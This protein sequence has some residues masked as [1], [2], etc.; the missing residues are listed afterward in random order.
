MKIINHEETK[1]G[2]M[3]KAFLAMLLF[4]IFFIALNSKSFA[5]TVQPL[6][7]ILFDGTNYIVYTNDYNKSF[8]Y[9]FG[10]SN[11]PPT[12]FYQCDTDENSNN[13]V[14]VPK[15]NIGTAQYLYT[16]LDGGKTTQVFEVNYGAA[17]N[18]TDAKNLLDLTNLTQITKDNDVLYNYETTKT[19]DPTNANNTISQTV[20]YAEITDPASQEYPNLQYKLVKLNGLATDTSTSAGNVVDVLN[21]LNTNVANSNPVGSILYMQKFLAI[22]NEFLPSSG[23]ATIPTDK[24]V[25]EPLDTKA[26]EV[27]LLYLTG[28]SKTTGKTETVVKILTCGQFESVTQGQTVV[29]LPKTGASF[30]LEGLL[31]IDVILIGAVY[32]RIRNLKKRI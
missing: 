10:D 24:K 23:W 11:T 8:E 14:I 4:A 1:W 21:Q 20:Y 18:S 30:L 2:N 22:Y 32:F 9:A 17:L 28:T 12:V 5:T 13:V 27:Y 3:A 6:E 25:R 31:A 16:T 15:A 26:N 19:T 7:S 29:K